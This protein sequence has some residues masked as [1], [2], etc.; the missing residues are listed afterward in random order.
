MTEDGRAVGTKTFVLRL[1]SEETREKA[2]IRMT[3]EDPRTR[4][5]R[6][7]SSFRELSRFAAM[8]FRRPPGGRSAEVSPSRRRSALLAAT[9]LLPGLALAEPPASLSFGAGEGRPGSAVTLPVLLRAANPEPVGALSLRV[10][11]EPS[12]AVESVS[13]RRAG[14]WSARRA[15]FEARPATDGSWSWIV[16]LAE[17]SPA[18]GTTVVGEVVVRLSRAA[19]AGSEV[20][21]RLDP[22]VSGF[23]DRAGTGFVSTATSGLVLSDGVVSVVDRPSAESPR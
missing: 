18:T 1:W 4:V 5:R 14:A 12:T 16:S 22:E 7:F 19:A 2:G 23:G 15:T 20:R 17:A 13:F 11:V 10:N 21:L 3:L 6:T 9:A 8:L